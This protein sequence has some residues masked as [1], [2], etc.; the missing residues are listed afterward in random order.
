MGGGDGGKGGRAWTMIGLD[1]IGIDW[2]G[3]CGRRFTFIAMDCT[4]DAG[5][6]SG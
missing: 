1:W 4:W 6:R 5:T 2:T 3:M